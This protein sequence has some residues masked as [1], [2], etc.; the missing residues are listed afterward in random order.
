MALIY[1]ALQEHG[2]ALEINASP[3]RLD[4]DDIHTRHAAGLGIPITI[5]TD[6][7]APAFLDEMAYGVSVA[8]RAWLEAAHVINTW[9]PT[10]LVEWLK[11]R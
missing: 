4:T 7:H 9:E 5:N 11:K 8:R 1:P 2:T 3:S 6:A 10:K